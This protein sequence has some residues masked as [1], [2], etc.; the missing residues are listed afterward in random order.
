MKSQ[1]AESRGVELHWREQGS[2]RPMVFLHGM[3]DSHAS[4]LPLT[5]AFPERRV[6]LL[7]LPG[8]GLSARP[9]ASYTP[10]WY[11]EVIA[12]WWDDLGLEDVDLV[13]HSYGGALAQLLLLSHKE[14]V[15][16]L[17]LLAPGG[18]GAEC[19]LGLRLL[20]LPGAGRVIQPFYG[21]GMQLFHRTIANTTMSR[22]EARDA[23]WTASRP[24]TGRAL[25][26]T[27]KAVIG[28]DGQTRL[29]TERARELDHLPPT[30]MLWGER[31]PIL[32][33]RHAHVAS[34]WLEGLT[35]KLYRGVGHFPHLENTREVAR[36]VSTH[37]EAR[38][39]PVRVALERVPPRRPGFFARAWRWVKRLFG[40]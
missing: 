30:A 13:G 12:G 18:H 36:D 34:S 29:V 7:D 2:G 37:L 27:A 20:T 33:V 4:W 9:D 11:G 28:W 16:T 14:R 26:R 38:G 32:P 15:E 5:R 6:L 40:R 24:G 39:R 21:A 8:H 10:E 1:F 23:G 25:A 22:E 19:G 17:T 31:D 3:G 35:V